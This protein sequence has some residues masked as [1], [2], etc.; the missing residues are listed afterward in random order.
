MCMNQ[1]C[2]LEVLSEQFQNCLLPLCKWAVQRNRSKDCGKLCCLEWLVYC[3]TRLALVYRPAL[4]HLQEL[5]RFL[6]MQS[7]L[8][9]G[10]QLSRLLWTQASRNCLPWIE[11]SNAGLNR[12]V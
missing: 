4:L 6:H 9:R 11:V 8:Y 5:E 3:L 7:F 2:K 1:G 12:L 10:E